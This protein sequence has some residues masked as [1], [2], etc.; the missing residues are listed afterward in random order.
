MS[1][2]ELVRTIHNCEMGEESDVLLEMAEAKG[3]PIIV[4]SE[5]TNTSYYT[6]EEIEEDRVP[7]FS[8]EY[9]FD[10]TKL[11]EDPTFWRD[12]GAIRYVANIL[13]AALLGMKTTLASRKYSFGD[14]PDWWSAFQP[15][16]GEEREVLRIE[17]EVNY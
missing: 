15:E 2:I 14:T 6:A 5:S 12:L 16:D 11:R 13:E 3:F 17:V 1:R 8:G 7:D 4:I 10:T 9:I